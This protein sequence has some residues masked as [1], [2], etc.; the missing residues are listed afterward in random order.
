MN[1]YFFTVLL[2]L[3]SQWEGPIPCGL[4]GAQK[5]GAHDLYS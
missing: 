1:G 5:Q 4:S 3:H 2:L